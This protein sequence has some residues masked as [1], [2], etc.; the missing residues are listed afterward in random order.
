MIFH[1]ESSSI[2]L[3]DPMR[4]QGK[5]SRQN[6]E[7][8]RDP[9]PERRTETVRNPLQSVT[10]TASIPIAKKH[11]SQEDLQKLIE[12]E[13]RES[14]FYNRMTSGTMSAPQR[15]HERDFLMMQEYNSNGLIIRPSP[16]HEDFMAQDDSFIGYEDVP[17]N[18][19]Q[20]YEPDDEAIFEMD[21]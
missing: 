9:V 18:D 11:S 21:L 4:E 6:S 10:K 1:T 16:F 20:G 12:A 14:Q 8:R 13:N 7:Q 2:I 15:W 19:Y 3:P 5:V 17:T